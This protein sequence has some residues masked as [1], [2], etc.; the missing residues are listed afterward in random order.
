VLAGGL[1]TADIMRDGKARV[2]TAAVGE[3]IVHELDKAAA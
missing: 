2:S 3:S 1:R